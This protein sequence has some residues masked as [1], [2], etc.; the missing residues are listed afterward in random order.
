TILHNTT[1]FGAGSGS[2]DHV[3]E[4]VASEITIEG[5]TLQGA[6]NEA[7]RVSNKGTLTLYFAGLADSKGGLDN[8]GSTAIVIGT[9]V[10]GNTGAGL[11]SSGGNNS[12]TV[13]RSLVT[14][15]TGPGI[16]IQN[17]DFDITNTMVVNN[18]GGGVV[19]MNAGATATFA[20]DT[21]AKNQT[22]IGGVQCN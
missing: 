18:P 1:G 17:G 6:T 14:G 3:V 8:N 16:Q 10:T 9:Q 12:L 7:A 21:I 19:I 22:T 4:D 20:F 15:S 5:M 2:L 13:H 11:S